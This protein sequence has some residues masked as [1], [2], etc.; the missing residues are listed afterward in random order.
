VPAT[1]AAAANGLDFVDRADAG[2]DDAG[3]PA[4]KRSHHLC[5][6]CDMTCS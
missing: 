6:C 4:G 1:V 5:H 2:S 3:A